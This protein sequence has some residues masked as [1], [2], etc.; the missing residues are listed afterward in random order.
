MPLTFA[1]L[2][3]AAFAVWGAAASSARWREW[4]WRLFLLA[5]ALAALHEAFM[6]WRGI[7]VAIALWGAAELYQRAASRRS[8][9]AWGFAAL[10]LAA[11]LATH[12]VPGFAPY[13]VVESVRV[14]PASAEMSLKANFD[15]AFA[16]VLLLA[17]FCDRARSLADWRRAIGIGLLVGAATAVVVIGLAIAAGAVRFDPKLPPITPAWMAANLML[18]CIFEEALFRGVIQDRLARWLADRRRWVWLPVSAA[19]VL[20][21]L[22]HAGGGPVLVIVAMIAGV[23]YGLAYATTGRVEAAIVAHFTLNSLHF[24]GFTYPYAVR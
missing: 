9:V 2:G 16:G 21:G 5:S 17:C 8:R 20:F 19:S 22:A 6:D 3:L 18:T 13:L 11:A 1:L 7:P 10:I 14:S 24:L 4:P 23:G 15:K 12:R